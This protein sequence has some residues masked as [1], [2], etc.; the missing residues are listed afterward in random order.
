LITTHDLQSLRLELTQAGLLEH[1]TGRSW[2][3]LSTLL[4]VLAGLIAATIVLPWW[5]AILLVPITAVIAATTAMFGHEAAHGSFAAG[6]LHNELVLHLVFPLFGGL[7][8][9]HWKSKH[10]QRHHGHP[11]VVG[12]DPDIEIWP[13]ALSS[14]AHA[15]SGRLRRW[16]Q[17]AVQGHLYWPLALL[18][19][20]AMRYESWRHLFGR[21]RAGKIDRALA[22]DLGCLIAHYTLWLVVPS[23]WFG[24]WPVVALYAGLWAV[25][26]LLLALVFTP[27]HV[28]LPVVREDEGGGWLL[29]LQTT[30]NL[31]MPRWLS[32]FFVGLDYQ[33]EH[34]LFP[35][36]P[37]QHLPRASAIVAAWCGRLGVP[38]HEMAYAAA[39]RDSTR[40]LRS[41]W[42]DVPVDRTAGAAQLS[43][44]RSR[45]ASGGTDEAGVPASG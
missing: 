27:A 13:I 35:R 3:K 42:Q 24:F 6:K 14:V 23:F 15:E 9:L 10:N 1:C 34:H 20:F 45:R 30:R 31:L 12:R 37:H 40:H 18:L 44:R 41:A 5:C 43:R 32:W 22:L 7:G 39:V 4:V 2:M 26:G 11:N 33:V 17:R 19:A 36:I 16:L 28:G 8:A 21:L 38:H 25:V 29:Q